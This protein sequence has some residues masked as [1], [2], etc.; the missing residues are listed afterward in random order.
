LPGLEGSG[1]LNI[2]VPADAKVFVNGYQTRS[3]GTQR[4]YVSH[5]LRP[6]YIYRYDVRVQIVR[7]GRT[8]E[9]VRT[10][11]LS[12]GA[13]E[14]LAFSFPATQVQEELASAF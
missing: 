13:R 2:R 1:T 5:G 3:V 7:D 9:E 4:R 14:A 11:Y 6:G 12:S 8:L 10:V